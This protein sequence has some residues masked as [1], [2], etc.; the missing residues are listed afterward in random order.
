[1]NKQE[2][3]VRISEKM[4]IP[5]LEALRFI[6]AMLETVSEELGRDGT[7]LLQGFGTFTPWKQ[8]ARV[9]RNPKT[10]VSCLIPPRTSV[11]FKPGKHLLDKLNGGG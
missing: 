4:D 1:M 6:H 5:Q 3:T 9:G 7:L 10:G 8:V 2:L 11:K